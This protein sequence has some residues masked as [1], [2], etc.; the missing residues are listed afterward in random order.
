MD[1]KHNN[2]I[3]KIA[4]IGIRVKKWIAFHGFSL[5]YQIV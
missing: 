2:K 1:R 5:N 4:A 3:E